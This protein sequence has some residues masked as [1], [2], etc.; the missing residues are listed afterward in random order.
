MSVQTIEVKRVLKNSTLFF[1]SWPLLP[2]F[3]DRPAPRFA[4]AEEKFVGDVGIY[5]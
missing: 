5:R 2:F 1:F 4:M 3:L